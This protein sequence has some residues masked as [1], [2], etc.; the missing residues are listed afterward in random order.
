M[1]SSVPEVPFSPLHDA[2]GSSRRNLI[3]KAQI[4]ISRANRASTDEVH[5]R[6]ERLASVTARARQ[7][8]ERIL[9]QSQSESRPPRSTVCKHPEVSNNDEFSQWVWTRDGLV[10]QHLQQVHAFAR[11]LLKGSAPNLDRNPS[12]ELKIYHSILG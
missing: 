11:H 8:H 4:L 3:S 2:Y 6:L 12:L 9:R 1:A 5:V 7:E 10:Y